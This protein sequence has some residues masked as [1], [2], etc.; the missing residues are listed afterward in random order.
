MRGQMGNIGQYLA[1]TEG[2]LKVAV[3]RMRKRFADC[4]REEIGQ[5][6]S[7][8]E[9]IDEELRSLRSFFF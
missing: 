1:M 8:P 4:L 2:A 3:H 5:T 6:V 7:C 9:E